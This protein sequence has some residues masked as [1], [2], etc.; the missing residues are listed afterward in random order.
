MTAFLYIKTKILLRKLIMYRLDIIGRDISVMHRLYF[1]EAKS[2][3]EFFL[4][5]PGPGSLVVLILYI[6]LYKQQN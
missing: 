3:V 1:E 6:Y 5:I 2:V 4:G